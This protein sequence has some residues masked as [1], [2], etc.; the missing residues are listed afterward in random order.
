VP[1]LEKGDLNFT[2]S[3]SYN[4]ELHCKNFHKFT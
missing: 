4:H 2:W 3:Q 1:I